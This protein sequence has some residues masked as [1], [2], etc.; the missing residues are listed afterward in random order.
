MIEMTPLSVPEGFI[1]I[2]RRCFESRRESDARDPRRP[3]VDAWTRQFHLGILC[4]IVLAASA[5]GCASRGP[6]A[7]AKVTQAERAVDDAQQA[8][9]AVS[10][11][12]DFRTAQDKLKAAREALAKGRHDRAIRSAE[13]AEIDGEYARAVAANQRVT[14]MSEEISQYINVLRQELQRLPK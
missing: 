9:A 1:R 3:T 6:L 11:P 5:L 4:C 12:V 13:Q 7:T 14:G 2:S 8:G 10:A